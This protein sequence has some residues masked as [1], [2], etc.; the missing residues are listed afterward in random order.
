MIFPHTENIGKEVEY[1]E[2]SIN[3]ECIIKEV[4]ASAAY[5]LTKIFIREG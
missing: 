3:Y 2:F 4:E 5:I 1:H